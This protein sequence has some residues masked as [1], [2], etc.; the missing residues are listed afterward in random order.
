MII[1]KWFCLDIFW[2]TVKSFKVCQHPI[3]TAPSCM[4]VTLSL[5]IMI[6]HYMIVANNLL[7]VL[8]STCWRIYLYGT[9]QGNLMM[10]VPGSPIV[11][12]WQNVK[13]YMV[14]IVSNNS[15]AALKD[16]R[17][18]AWLKTDS[19][20]A[21]PTCWRGDWIQSF[22]LPWMVYRLKDLGKS[23]NLSFYSSPKG[24]W[25]GRLWCVALIRQLV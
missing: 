22:T 1:Y 6:L 12:R 4:V 23:K 11:N 15:S 8:W 14:L 19:Y 3:T 21:T 18:I 24:K 9:P 16:P 25:E 10:V 17:S 13:C 5:K 7:R 20:T 2:L